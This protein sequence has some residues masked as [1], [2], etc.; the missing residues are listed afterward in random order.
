MREL[1]NAPDKCL[2]DEELDCDYDKIFTDGNSCDEA[3][4]PRLRK[5]KLLNKRKAVPVGYSFETGI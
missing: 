5:R 3:T 2:L 1:I 4:C